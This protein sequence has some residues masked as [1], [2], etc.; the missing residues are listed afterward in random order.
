MKNLMLLV[1]ILIGLSSQAYTIKKTYFPKSAIDKTQDYKI[2]YLDSFNNLQQL[3]INKELDMDGH[4]L[5][6]NTYHYLNNKID[7]V[8]KIEQLFNTDG[9]LA[10]SQEFNTWYIYENEVLKK[11][12]I[13][14]LNSIDSVFNFYDAIGQ[15]L[16]GRLKYTY[17]K[18]GRIT[19]S[20]YKA[21]VKQKSLT[22][23]TYNKVG[24]LATIKE[25]EGKKVIATTTF[26]YNDAGHLIKE[27]YSFRKAKD[28]HEATT[29]YVYENDLLKAEEYTS[30]HEPK[31]TV[32]YS[33]E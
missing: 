25:V 9:S 19:T 13:T 33:Y 12:A 6:T 8:T 5:Y 11:T 30:D 14:K 18:Q 21:K 7:Y 27:Y 4:V 15:T 10:S 1:S 3:I 26:S 31:E 2:N 28:A 22:K 29:N 32:L 24:K 17:D 16:N 23:Y 20:I